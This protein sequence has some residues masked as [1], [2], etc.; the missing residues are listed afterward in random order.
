MPR[1]RWIAWMWVAAATAAPP[2]TVEVHRRLDSLTGRFVL[3]SVSI[4]I[5][6]PHVL[7]RDGVIVF[8][9][10]SG[11]T[12]AASEMILVDSGGGRVAVRDGASLE[13]LPA[14][15]EKLVLALEDR[16]GRR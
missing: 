15:A 3:P 7:R 10:I 2:C 5:T 9:E 11:A 13:L 16:D 8:P 12:T 14:P 1:G 6:L 4:G